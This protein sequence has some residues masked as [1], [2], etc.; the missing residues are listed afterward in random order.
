ML[1]VNNIHILFFSRKTLIITPFYFQIVSL[2]HFFSHG[3]WDRI[4]PDDHIGIDHSHLNDTNMKSRYTIFGTC[5]KKAL[6][7]V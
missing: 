2:P 7:P 1:V 5:L 3:N 4:P 6:V